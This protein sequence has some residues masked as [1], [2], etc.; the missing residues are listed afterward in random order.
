M[1][2]IKLAVM[3][4]IWTEWLSHFESVSNKI[5]AIAART[6]EELAARIVDADVV[7]TNT[8]G[9][10]DAAMAEHAL[11]LILSWTGGII[12]AEPN[13]HDRVYTREIPVSQIDGR[14]VCVLSLRTLGRNVSIRLHHIGMHVIA[15]DAQVSAPPE[16]VDELVEGT[17]GL[18]DQS[19]FASMPDHTYLVNIPR[20]PIVNQSDLI[21]ALQSQAIAGTGIDIFKEE[22][23]PDDCLLWELSN[24]VN[25]P[26]LGG[27]SAEGYR[28]V[29]DISC[30][31]HRRYAQGKQLLNVVDKRRG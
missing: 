1:R 8:A 27:R 17:R 3:D 22:P 10:F 20:R 4:G 30:E 24:A 31:N 21:K 26:H 5:E 28:N 6:D 13:R 2:R 14:R 12:T 18:I 29:R 25:T 7:R 19:C 9:A 15:V 16:G 11:A 23:L